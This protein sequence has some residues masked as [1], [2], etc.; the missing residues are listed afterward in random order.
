MNSQN[1]A[2]VSEKKKLLDAQNEPSAEAKTARLRQEILKLTRQRLKIAKQYT[3]CVNP[4]PRCND[5]DYVSQ[6]LMRSLIR[7]QAENTRVALEYAQV[8]ANKIALDNL[9][10]EKNEDFQ[11]ALAEFD[12]GMIVPHSMLSRV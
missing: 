11:K 10:K 5:V 7:D 3:V 8:G 9:C 6:E 2:T 12:Q 4:R 1:V